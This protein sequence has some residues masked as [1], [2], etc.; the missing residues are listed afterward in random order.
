MQEHCS[1]IIHLP[2]AN[3]VTAFILIEQDE[4]LDIKKSKSY[5]NLLE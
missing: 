2:V 3:V 5:A 1:T 4:I